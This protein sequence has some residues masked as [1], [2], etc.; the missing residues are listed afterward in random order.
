MAKI[1]GAYGVPHTPAFPALVDR[2]G[3]GCEVAR[4]YTRVRQELAAAGADVVVL[5][6]SDH[7]NTFF[8][9]VPTFAV[10]VADSFDGPNDATDGLAPRTVPSDRALAATLHEGLTGLGFDPT[11]LRRF[12]ADHSVLVPVHFLL[13]DLGIPVVPVYVNGI[14]SPLPAA[15][16]CAALGRAVTA[17]LADWPDHLRVA[18]VAS[19]SFSLEVGGPRIASARIWGVPAPQWS[20]RVVECVRGGEIDALVREATPRQLHRA[21]NV[22]GELLNWIS[23]LGALGG[24]RPVF[25]EPQ[26]R[27]GH[28]YA[29]WRVPA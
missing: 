24:S 5:F 16:R 22:G 20:A 18:L 14:V 26:E 4:L 17:V 12:A 2:E 1:V 29:A 8:D 6:D 27:F 11:Q 28:S 15:E 23:L 25:C 9:H 21:G 3:P 7:L 10:G 13:P 19:G